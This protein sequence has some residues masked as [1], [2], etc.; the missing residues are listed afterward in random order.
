MF[1]CD[2]MLITTKTQFFYPGFYCWENSIRTVI[3]FLY[4]EDAYGYS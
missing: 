2:M 4:Q 3:L 1:Y